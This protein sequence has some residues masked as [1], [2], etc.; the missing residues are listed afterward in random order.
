VYHLVPNIHY[1][2]RKPEVKY[3]SCL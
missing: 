3:L 1:G 2:G